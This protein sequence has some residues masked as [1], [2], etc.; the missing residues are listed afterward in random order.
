MLAENPAFVL[1]GHTI[2]WYGIVIAIG[3]LLGA[4][5]GML[6]EKR[7]HLP[8]DTMIDIALCAVPLGIVCARIYYVAFSWDQ[9]KGDIWR[10][11]NIH[12][13]GIAIYGGIIGGAVGVYLYSRFK[14]LPFLQ[15]ADLVVPGLAIAQGIGRWGNFFN[16]E[17]Y[18][19]AVTNAALQHFPIAVFIEQ[20]QSWHYAT[21]FYEF[22]WCMLAALI[23][24]IMERRGAIKR[25]GDG[26]LI[27]LMMYMAE[28][29]I[30]EGLR[31]DSLMFMHIR[32]SQ[33]LSI[34]G[35]LFVC[36]IFARRL[37]DLGTSIGA[38][39]HIPLAIVLGMAMLI[40][41]ALDLSGWGYLALFSG[42]SLLHGFFI[43]GQLPN[44]KPYS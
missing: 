38:K 11:I 7:L 31:T 40:C 6:R 34:A 2:Y 5:C 32:V 36:V 4:L 25:I 37:S 13:G 42:L 43:Y 17:A 26:F 44:I 30:V 8:K 35:L 33:M 28:R 19:I 1:F 9:F 14:K 3:A 41:A 27:Y 39:L 29:T 21:F 16:Q 20:V 12:E 24:I 18:G 22:I 15:L 10:I 23:L